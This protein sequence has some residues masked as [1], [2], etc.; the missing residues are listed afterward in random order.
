MV[1]FSSDL[2]NWKTLAIMT[3]SNG[4]ANILDPT[5]GLKQRYYRALLVQ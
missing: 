3:T 2:T 1:R 5:T 4:T